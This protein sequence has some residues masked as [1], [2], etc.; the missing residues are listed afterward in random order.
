MVLSVR[1][2]AQ[3]PGHGFSDHIQGRT[4]NFPTFRLRVD[5]DFNIVGYFASSVRVDDCILDASYATEIDDS[6]FG[7]DVDSLGSEVHVETKATP[8]PS[9]I[10]T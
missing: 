6:C 9:F 1:K 10:P 5:R 8:T 2:F 3:V 7:S 4:L